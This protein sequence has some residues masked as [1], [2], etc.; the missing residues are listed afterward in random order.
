MRIPQLSHSLYGDHAFRQT[1]TSFAVREYSRHGIDLLRTPLPIFGSHANVPF[2]FPLLQ[3]LAALLTHL[4]TSPEMAARMIGLVTFQISVALTWALAR[5]WFG[6]TTAHVSAFVMELLP[7]GLQWG[8]AALI[9]FGSVAMAMAM[10]LSLDNYFRRGGR[11]ALALVCAFSC[12]TG[13]VKV[14]TLI[15]WSIA[16]G[17]AA[18]ALPRTRILLQRAAVGLGA[19]PVS[20]FAAAVLWTHHA[21]SVKATDPATRFITSEALRDWNFGTLSERLS[22]EPY[23]ALSHHAL[24]EVGSPVGISVAIAGAGAFWGAGNLWHRLALAV[25]FISAPLV[26][27]YLYAVHSYYWIAIFPAFVILCA[28]GIV[29]MA[30]RLQP[31][32]R[33]GAGVVAA[34]AGLLVVTAAVLP[35]GS[36][37]TSQFM[38]DNAPPVLAADL[39]RRTSPLEEVLVIGCDWDPTLLYA[40]DRQGFMV[41][42]AESASLPPADSLSR[43]R[44]LV[45]CSLS[46]NP[47]DYLPRGWHSTPTDDPHFYTIARAS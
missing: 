39:A 13:L 2:E 18:L 23:L 27:F 46:L 36:S 38:H 44:V 29:T 16:A 5:R 1:Q 24:L 26:L 4:G 12:L 20:G 47:D 41:R 33:L 19:G 21:D 30:A 37:E 22:I 40:A 8:A 32:G 25:G 3:T 9:D 35:L 15:P 34:L 31:A 7:F 43:Y 17:V 28:L 11:Q 45:R 10:V 14:T 6:V 42:G